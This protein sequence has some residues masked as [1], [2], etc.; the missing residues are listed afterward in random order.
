MFSTN[1]G[2]IVLVT[3]DENLPARP[4]PVPRRGGRRGQPA[5][6]ANQPPQMRQVPS[7]FTGATRDGQSGTIYVKVVNV[8]GTPQPVQIKV[9]GVARVE[10]SGQL[11]EMKGAGLT[12]TNSITERTKIVP[13]TTKIDG[14]STDFTRTFPPYSVSVLVLK[15][16]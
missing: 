14:L 5:P 2:N 9:S 6:D 12:D 4:M 10:S 8:V 15:T 3:S 7:L 1:H 16:K 11:V 13:V